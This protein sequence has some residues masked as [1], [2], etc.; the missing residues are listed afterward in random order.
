[1]SQNETKI[2]ELSIDR[3]ELDLCRVKRADFRLTTDT[4]LIA[5]PAVFAGKDFKAS[6]LLNPPMPRL[7][8][9]KMF[10]GIQILHF[11]SRIIFCLFLIFPVFSYAK[12]M[13]AITTEWINGY[14]IDF[15]DVGRGDTFAV[16]FAVPVGT[17][18]DYGRFMG[19]AHLLEHVMHTGTRAFPGHSTI[20]RVLKP[21]GASVNAYTGLNR[22]VYYAVGHQSSAETIIQAELSMLSG[23]EWNPESIEKEKRVVI[24]EIVD[25][26]MKTEGDAVN[27]LPYLK[28]LRHD[29]PF[30]H[31]TLG[32]RESLESLSIND[33]KEMY[34]QNYGP[35]RV[36]IA[37]LGNFR[38]PELREKSRH[39]VQHYLRMPQWHEDKNQYFPRSFPLA[40][41]WIPSLFSWDHNAPESEA[42]IYIETKDNKWSGML[43]EAPNAFFPKNPEAAD[44]FNSY[45]NDPSP[46]GLE[47]TLKFKLGWASDMTFYTYRVNNRNYL[48]FEVQL[49]DKGLGHEEDINELFFKALRSI[50]NAPPTEEWLAMEKKRS[51]RDM[52]LASTSVGNFLRPYAQVLTSP[53]SLDEIMA[54][55]DKVTAADIQRV[56]RAFRPDQALYFYSGD[57]K[58]EMH[59]DEYGYNRKY[60]LEDNRAALRRYLE[61]YHQPV[62]EIF[63]PQPA[64]VN[65]G[66]PAKKIE[67]GFVTNVSPTN[68]REILDIR[69]DL[70]DAAIQLVM[71]VSPV[72]QVD[73]IAAQIMGLA[74]KERYVGEINFIEKEYSMS[75]S[76]KVYSDRI[77][78]SAEGLDS[79]AARLLA[80]RLQELSTFVPTEAELVRARQ[81]LIAQVSDQMNSQ[82]AAQSANENT[83]AKLDRLVRTT[84]NTLK[85]AEELPREHIL[86]RWQMLRRAGQYRL[87]ASGAFAQADIEAVKSA[88]RKFSPLTLQTLRYHPHRYW[89]PGEKSQ[90]D[91]MLFP[92][93][94]GE[95]AFGGVRVFRGPAKAL[96]KEN[97]AFLAAISLI[98][99]LVSS[100]NRAFQEL[101]YMHSAFLGQPD[102]THW[103][104]FIYGGTEGEENSRKMLKGWEH[105]LNRLR[106]GDIEDTDIQAAI[107]DQLNTVSRT[108]TSAENWVAQYNANEDSFGSAAS[109]PALA[110][111]LRE[112]TPQDVRVVV[113]KY[114]VA[115][116][117]PYYQLTMSNCEKAL[118]ADGNEQVTNKITQNVSMD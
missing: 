30:N 117:T 64:E 11:S 92:A 91:H 2:A 118:T 36:R 50:E 73:M 72:D 103:S 15:V 1:M 52:T 90:E 116:Q 20:D 66:A 70:R 89:W 112:L 86:S 3:V 80:W 40:N 93:P 57:E 78:F 81:N 38:T 51:V 35:G 47:H 32:D 46:G 108:H 34:Y 82:F 44:Y 21:A 87:T 43:L 25:E 59:D 14:Q 31:P 53:H 29:H 65:L 99:Q 107:S 111:I 110:K 7:F 26:Y 48:R 37:I 33:L 113:Q 101:G 17:M 115:P 98:E 16:T 69:T 22:T 45:M 75:P 27:Q 71:F 19:R 39:W 84:P 97:A 56:A 28:L 6:A 4:V 85:L 94:K 106:S 61:L 104:L 18:H 100:H 96:N 42:K 83:M 77:E 74:F 55:A 76:M 13:P 41:R 105:V 67:P 109:S 95:G 58:E 62:T 114:I 8:E 23:L 5:L 49:T 63:R 88:A 24:N 10:R 9:T 60:K 68:D 102:R 54:N 12:N 79:R